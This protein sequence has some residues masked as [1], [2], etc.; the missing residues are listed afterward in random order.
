M[1]ISFSVDQEH[2]LLQ[3]WC[4]AAYMVVIDFFSPLCVARADIQM[5]YLEVEYPYGET[6][7][8]VRFI[9]IMSL[10]ALYAALY[11]A[12]PEAASYGVPESIASGVKRMLWNQG[13]TAVM[14][15]ALE[16]KERLQK[17]A[18]EILQKNRPLHID[19]MK[20]LLQGP[21]TTYMIEQIKGRA[22]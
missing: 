8:E 1:K 18:A 4:I 3:A 11:E 21:V 20:M 17:L 10:L 2:K 5:G 6:E 19:L 9:T 16:E 13:I 15:P 12:A 22:S 14:E 7:K